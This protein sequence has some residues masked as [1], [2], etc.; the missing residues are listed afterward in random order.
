MKLRAVVFGALVIAATVGGPAAA[1]EGIHV[2]P[3]ATDSYGCYAIEVWNGDV[4]VRTI[5]ASHVITATV[6]SLRAASKGPPSCRAASSCSRCVRPPSRSVGDTL[7]WASDGTTDG[8]VQLGG[9]GEFDC[10]GAWQIVGRS[11]YI[12]QSCDL[13]DDRGST[14]I[15]ATRGTPA[16]T[17]TLP[18]PL[19][20][21]YGRIPY[22][23]LHGRIFYIA[24]HPTKGSELW[25]SG[26]TRREHPR[27][28]GHLAGRARLASPEPLV[29]RHPAPL[30]RERRHR[31]EMVGERRDTRR[32]PPGVGPAADRLRSLEWPG[33]DRAGRR[34]RRP[35]PGTCWTRYGREAVDGSARNDAGPYPA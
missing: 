23:V 14:W 31:P 17:W 22:V 18:G 35:G 3:G 30:H 34:A 11:A 28:E 33:N 7:V 10:D 26:G 21:T 12:S 24:T 16:S 5:P 32:H 13:G 27:R 8:T 19:Q 2:S 25:V 4:L 1:E 29:G 20:V 9:Y 6:P 15:V